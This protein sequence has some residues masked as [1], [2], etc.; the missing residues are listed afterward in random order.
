MEAL[1]SLTP[2]A[3]QVAAGAVGGNLVGLLRGNR[4]LGPLLNS[5]LGSAGGAGAVLTLHRS[6]YFE[7]ATG[8]L[9]SNPGLTE[10]AAGGIGGFLLP[11]LLSFFKRGS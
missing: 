11:F 4:S 3:I 10:A 1:E 8:W 9:A 5:V 7:M 6:G 2:W